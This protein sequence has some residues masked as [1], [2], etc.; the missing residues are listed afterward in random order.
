MVKVHL[1]GLKDVFQTF[2]VDFLG[3]RNDFSPFKV[4]SLGLGRSLSPFDQ[5]SRT[6]KSS[7]NPTTSKQ[8]LVLFRSNLFIFAV[9]KYN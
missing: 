6:S 8:M 3:L 4:H 5:H 9:D 7:D 2:K 1:L